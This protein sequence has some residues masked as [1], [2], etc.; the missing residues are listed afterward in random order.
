MPAGKAVKQPLECRAVYLQNR[1][2]VVERE[3]G[4]DSKAQ[5]IKDK[6]ATD[7]RW[8]AVSMKNDWERIFAEGVTKKK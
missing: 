5:K 6:C 1:E 3:Y 2:I 4:D 7:E 8:V